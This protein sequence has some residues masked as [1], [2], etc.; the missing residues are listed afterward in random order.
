MNSPIPPSSEILDTL[1]RS[2]T[3]DLLLRLGDH[4]MQKLRGKH[5]RGVIDGAVPG[6]QEASDLVH[7]AIEAV[8]TGHRRWDPYKNPDLCQY[9]ESV[10]DSITSAL[11][12]SAENRRSSQLEPF[13]GESEQECIDR[14]RMRH[15]YDEPTP[16]EENR[17]YEIL[18]RLLEDVKDDQLLYQI[19]EC[20]LIEQISKR[21]AVAS[22]LGVSP[23]DV[24]QALK[25]LSRRMP[26]FKAKIIDLIS[27]LTA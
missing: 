27:P 24:T 18:F 22:H 23:N 25:R 11:V 8:L 6:G 1:E 5:W 26:K 21:E 3:A 12:E 4:A 2:I 20:M 13:G 16:D 19:V 9:L 7:S 17:N 14:L 15:C 10:I